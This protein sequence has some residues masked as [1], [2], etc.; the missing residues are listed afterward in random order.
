VTRLVLFAEMEAVRTSMT[1]ILCPVSAAVSRRRQ[2]LCTLRPG[3]SKKAVQYRRG[4]GTPVSSG[5]FQHQFADR[6]GSGFHKWVPLAGASRLAETR[7]SAGI[8][9]GANPRE[10]PA[11]TV[12]AS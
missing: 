2:P 11:S 4:V 6:T 1:R 12:A 5:V 10:V 8:L 3:E 7:R 9:A